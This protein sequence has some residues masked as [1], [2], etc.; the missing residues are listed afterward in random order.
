MHALNSKG[1]AA[2]RYELDGPSK[3]VPAVANEFLY[4]AGGDRVTAFDT[5]N[6][7]AW[8]EFEF[9]PADGVPEHVLA[10]GGVLVVITSRSRVVAFS[11][12]KR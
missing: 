2:I 4:A 7:R 9:K 12:D 3:Y 10:G 6:E 11:Q 5:A 8:W 1:K